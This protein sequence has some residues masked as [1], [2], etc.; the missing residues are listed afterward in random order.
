MRMS[1]APATLRWAIC[2]AGNIS[3]DF[4]ISLNT[5]PK[6]ENQILA[7][8]GR[9]LGKTKAFADKFLIPRVYTS[10]EDIAQDPD[11]DVV[12][13]GTFNIS[14][15][16]VTKLMLNHGK[17]V[18]C[19]K[20][21]TLLLR[22]TEELFQLARQKKRFLMEACWTRFFPACVK[23]REC[24]ENKAYLG[25]IKLVTAQFGLNI[26]HLDRLRN[27]SL[28][29]GSLMDL[30]IYC[31][32]FAMMVYGN[33]MP[34]EILTSVVKSHEGVD[35]TLALILKY[36][37]GRIAQLTSTIVARIKCE[38]AIYG[39]GQDN[40]ALRGPNGRIEEASIT[41][42]HPF[43]SA[44]DLITPAG[45]EHFPLPAIEIP[46]VYPHGQGMRYEI[47]ETR[48][49]VLA[50]DIESPGFTHQDSITL[51][52]IVDLILKKIDIS[53]DFIYENGK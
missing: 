9:E 45:R 19:E 47:D 35:L 41:L 8:A 38:A 26:I 15:Y 49:C 42:P 2:G 36:K 16:E 20:P 13:V 25:E 43:W 6:G 10:Y 48:R 53:Y 40:P 7:V 29:G 46:T 14:H 52:K 30:G 34:E 24:V 50:G 32:Q 44:T 12:Y 3:N 1:P 5:L 21:I 27:L 39:D 23:L 4:A 28:G 37:G 22:H 17:H 11:I 31:I 33:E 18:L 51:A